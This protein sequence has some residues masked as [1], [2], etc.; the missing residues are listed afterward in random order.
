LFELDLA[1]PTLPNDGDVGL[2]TAA[3]H[4]RQGHLATCIAAYKHAEAIDPRNR[5]VLYDASQTYFGLR[6]WQ[7]AAER[8][9]RVLALAPDALNVKI[10]R[11]YIEFY[12]TGSTAAI[13]AALD[14]IPP[15]IDPDGVVTFA[16]WDV[17]MMERDTTAAEKALAACRLETITAQT[18]VSF[19]RLICKPASILFVTTWERRELALNWP[20]RV[21]KGQSPTVRKTLFGVRSSVFFML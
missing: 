6:D 20:V 3:V 7:T 5:V 9:D 4:R 15:N 21:W 16:R 11:G 18:G 8:M 2:F 12:R 14:R 10:Q 13:K 1:A 19:R 17:A